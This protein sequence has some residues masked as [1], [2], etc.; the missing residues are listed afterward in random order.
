MR[1]LTGSLS[2]ISRHA[3]GSDLSRGRRIRHHSRIPGSA[4]RQ[5]GSD[6]DRVRDT[7]RAGV[8]HDSWGQLAA[9]RAQI[10]AAQAQVS[11]AQDALKGV[12]QE[13]SAG[14]RTTIDVLNA[15]QELISAR[16]TLVANSAR[17]CRDILCRAGCGGAPRPRGSPPAG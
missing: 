5:N 16:V 12:L 13:A 15:Q 9:A 14:Q 6:L 4:C 7:V 8:L 10:E 3:V 2:R 11:A 17:S 1:S